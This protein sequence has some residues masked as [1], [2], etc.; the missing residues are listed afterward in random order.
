VKKLIGRLLIFFIGIPAS[1]ALFA[2]FPY[3]NHLAGNI[4]VIV[5]CGLGAVE[6]SG[7]L[8]KKNLSIS[9]IKAG[10]FGAVVPVGMT[11]WVS[12]DVGPL[13]IPALVAANSGWM[14]VSGVFVSVKQEAAGK[15]PHDALNHAAAGFAAMFYPSFFLSWIILMNRLPNSTT[16]IIAFL[17]VV[18]A[19][20]SL[21]WT[22]GLL[23]G[24]TNQG[25]FAVSP[26]K[27][28]AGF[29]GGLLASVAAGIFL[30]S[31]LPQVFNPARF[32]PLVSGLV[33]GMFTG[34]AAVLGD[35][36][37]SALKRDAGVKDSGGLI[38]GRGGILDSCDSLALSAPVFYV[39]YR[40]LF[41]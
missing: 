14:L 15:T 10:I 19:N 2:F 17:C 16:L 26:N 6:L 31:A 36:A 34:V 22:A 29:I 18:F 5:F 41:V 30:V 4:L 27:S 24:R 9:R 28:A 39:V 38:P 20:D 33:L 37:E 35:L 25:I 11:L 13:V 23:F 7:M 1:I 21:A 32:P 40:L 8:K 3:R 12:F